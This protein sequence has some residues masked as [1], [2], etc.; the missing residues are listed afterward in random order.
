MPTPAD[1]KALAL[2]YAYQALVRALVES[3]ALRM[4]DLFKEL[5]GA[6]AAATRVGEHGA[7]AL[8]GSL[9]EQMQGIE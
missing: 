8:L 4:D 6:Q 1:E 3:N 2:V 7:A 5:A 9:A